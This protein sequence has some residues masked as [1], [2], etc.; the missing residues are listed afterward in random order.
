MMLK[1]I[2]TINTG[3]M[4]YVL[5]ISLHRPGK[6]RVLRTIIRRQPSPIGRRIKCSTFREM[7][8]SFGE[9]FITSINKNIPRE[10][11]LI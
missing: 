6:S 2:R 8:C 10:I 7:K 9:R 11:L 1:L 3:N 5:L 4:C